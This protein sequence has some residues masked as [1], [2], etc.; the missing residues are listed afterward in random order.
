MQTIDLNTTQVT[1]RDDGVMHIH[2]RSGADMQLNDAVAVIDAM[3]KLGKGKKF[4]VLIDAGEFVTVDK[5]VRLFSASKEGNLYT[6]ADAIAYCSFAQKLIADFYVR[7][8]QPIV[9]TRTFQEKEEAIR[10]L[11]TFLIPA[12]A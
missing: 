3:Y 9:P 12:K 8:N 7:H 5:E 1:L 10:W 4:P 6:L 2:I 11:K